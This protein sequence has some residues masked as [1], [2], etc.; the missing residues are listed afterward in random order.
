MNHNSDEDKK[1]IY[2][3]PDRNESITLNLIRESEP[4]HNY[5]DKS[6]GKILDIAIKRI[7]QLGLDGTMLDAGCGMGRLTL[8]FGKYFREIHACEPD[9]E[10]Y[11]VFCKNINK[12]DMSHKVKPYLG[13]AEKLE[14]S[15]YFDIII[16]SHVIQHIQEDI[17]EKM[18][19]SFGRMLKENGL[20]FIT[21]THSLED[22]VVF[23]ESY[24]SQSGE[25]IETE[26]SQERFNNLNNE[27]GILPIKF[28]ACDNIKEL[29]E[30]HGFD[31]IDFRVY[32]NSTSSKLLD[33]IFGIDSLIN[34]N[35]GLRKRYGRDLFV[36]ARKTTK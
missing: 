18:M 14:F 13:G 7:K 33:S 3:Y 15:E 4:Y 23:C 35:S 6:E 28:F 30:K 27:A 25:R 2:L 8:K 20:L 1:G 31:M 21:T 10:R 29:I 5:W 22:R 36:W 19:A 9:T 34:L 32:H 12:W 26:I 24:M 16:C 17:A 11:S